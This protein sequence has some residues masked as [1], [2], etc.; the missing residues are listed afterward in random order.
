M[1]ARTATST[2]TWARSMWTADRPTCRSATVIWEMGSNVGERSRT[3]PLTLVEAERREGS[4]QLPGWGTRQPPCQP[5]DEI[6]DKV[7]PV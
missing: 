3:A 1:V 7:E 2:V 5:C 6:Q 4:I